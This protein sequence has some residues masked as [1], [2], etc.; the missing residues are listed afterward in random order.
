MESKAKLRFARVSP[1]K[2]RLVAD[3][4][5]GRDVDEALELLSFTRKKT[6]PMIKK[7]IE[8]AVANAEESARVQDGA[9]D[10]DALYVKTITVDQGPRCGAIGLGPRGGRPPIRK[11]TSHISVVLGL[12]EE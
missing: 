2:A 7:L 1:R 5:R 10:I 9:V 12:R 11:P 4:V 6:A 3:L 8:S